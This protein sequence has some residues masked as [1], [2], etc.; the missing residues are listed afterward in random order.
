VQA[1]GGPAAPRDLFLDAPLADLEADTLGAY[2]R[3]V[4]PLASAD[5]KRTFRLAWLVPCLGRRRL[6]EMVAAAHARGIEA[7]FWATPR[8]WLRTYSWKMQL[9]EHV[10]WLNVDDLAAAA[11]F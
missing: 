9:E 11:R 3:T 7:R 2:T 10:D 6:R 5:F 8:G 4:S 1:L